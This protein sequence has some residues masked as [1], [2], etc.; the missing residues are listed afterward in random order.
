MRAH[1]EPK[2]LRRRLASSPFRILSYRLVAFLAVL[3]PGFV[4]A[5]VDNDP[6]GI[7]TYSQAGAKYG[8]TL[9]WTLI[10]TTLALIVVQEMAARMGVAILSITHFSKAGSGT[11]SKALHR[12]IGSIAFV[13][14]P[15]AAFAVVADT[16]NEGRMLLLHAKNNMA[17]KPPGLA[18]RL[19][20]TVVSDGIVASYV[21]WE[22]TPVTIRPTRR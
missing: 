16:D 5:N 18:Y 12:F 9:L 4:T 21:H 10:P 8:Y 7:L 14:A 13:G 17:P 20:Q 1:I 6:G 11:T 15:R 19:L 22:D 3:G 2:H